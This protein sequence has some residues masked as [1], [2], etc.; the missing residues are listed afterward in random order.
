MIIYTLQEPTKDEINMLYIFT[1]IYFII[2][3]LVEFH[4]IL[5]I[6]PTKPHVFNLNTNSLIDSTLINFVYV[7]I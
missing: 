6:K 7:F 4:N 1:A 3:Y 5:L 2:K